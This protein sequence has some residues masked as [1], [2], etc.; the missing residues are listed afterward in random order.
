V[1]ATTKGTISA[2]IELLSLKDK[3][4]KENLLTLSVTESL[5]GGLVT[6]GVL[7]RLGDEL[8]TGV[9]GLDGLLG[10]LG[11]SHCKLRTGAKE[12]EQKF[13]MFLIILEFFGGL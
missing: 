8:E 4:S 1:L 5:Q 2:L 13:F 11:R 10:L 9:D 6:K 3:M 7:S 12:E